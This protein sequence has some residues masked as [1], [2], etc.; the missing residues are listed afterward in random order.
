[1]P[2][3]TITIA[4]TPDSD[5]AFCFDALENGMVEL[6]GYQFRFVREHMAKLDVTPQVQ[7]FATDAAPLCR[8]KPSR[9]E[10]R[11]TTR[12]RGSIRSQ[13]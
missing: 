7:I 5:D 4:Y 12:I 13:Q 11:K 9:S 3:Q 8:S 10:H 6:P 1:M 2:Q